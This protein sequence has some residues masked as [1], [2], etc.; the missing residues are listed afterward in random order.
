MQWITRRTLVACAF[1]VSAAPALAQYPDR[2][3]K[4]IS[5]APPGGSTDIM[6]R[7]LQ[8]GMQ[9][10][11]KQNVIVESRGGAGGYI[12]SDAVAKSPPDGYT[13]LLG[14]AFTANTAL[15]KKKSAYDPRKD[16]VP[17]SIFAMVPNVL[18]AGPSLKA[19]SVA[20]LIAM[21]KANPDKLNVGSNGV[22]TTLHL[23]AELLK[24][25]TGISLT[26][27]PF[28]GWSDCM[29]AVVNGEVDFMFD[30]LNTAMP[31]ILDGKLR[32]LA[33]TDAKRHPSLPNV[34]T[35]AEL[36]I[37]DAEV[38]SW[39]GIMVPANMPQPV[40][41]KLGQTFKGIADAPDF[42]RLITQ[43]GMDAVFIGQADAAKFWLAEIDR[44]EAIIKSSGIEMQD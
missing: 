27:V 38:T 9:E 39:F 28:R 24:L 5:P 33:V 8:P 22:G 20:E 30:N 31:N 44:W 23:S 15:L 43:Q 12:G 37:K 21:A 13:V 42:K 14:G 17:V 10:A 7:L 18:V 3:I 29:V 11:L 19:N 36:G 26:H 6:S 40:V 34:P 1:V 35:L 4:I 41:D 32:P 25:R 16:L 2:M